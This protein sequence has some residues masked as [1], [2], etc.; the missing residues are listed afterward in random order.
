MS[1]EIATPG[2]SA[3]AMANDA[4]RTLLQEALEAFNDTRVEV[5]SL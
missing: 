4:S 5:N 3:T 2:S 1:R